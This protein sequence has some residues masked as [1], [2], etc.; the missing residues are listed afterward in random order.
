MYYHSNKDYYAQSSFEANKQFDQIETTIAHLFRF[1]HPALNGRNYG[2]AFCYEV[3]RRGILSNRYERIIEV[4]GGT[5]HFAQGFLQELRKS[6]SQME[7]SIIDISPALQQAQQDLLKDKARFILGDAQALP[8]G[9]KEVNGLII[10]NE[11]V[12]DLDAVE[13]THHEWERS[14][15]PIVEQLRAA[16]PIEDE[17]ILLNIGA[18]KFINEAGRVLADGGCAVITEHGLEGNGRIAITGRLDDAS[19]SH[20]EYSINFNHLRFVAESIG[21]QA[22][23]IQLIDFLCFDQDM[24]VANL[25]DAQGLNGADQNWSISAIPATEIAAIYGCT[26]KDLRQVAGLRLPKIGGEGFP[27]DNTLPF[28]LSF[29]ALILKK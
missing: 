24:E 28:S 2:A 3:I 23:I 6:D 17:K 19:R 10:C 27:D 18:I 1:P 26:I 16:F 22:E 21:F 20:T 15:D 4:G 12:A 7:Y 14:Q 13:M 9:A 25:N 11:V 29:K 5:G 8:F